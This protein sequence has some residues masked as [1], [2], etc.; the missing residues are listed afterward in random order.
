MSET[1]RK[2]PDLSVNESAERSAAPPLNQIDIPFEKDLTDITPIIFLV[3]MGVIVALVFILAFASAGIV[4]L[5][6]KIAFIS[7]AGLVAVGI[8]SI[9]QYYE[10]HRRADIR[11]MLDELSNR[12]LHERLESILRGN[13]SMAPQRM[14]REV[15]TRIA[16]DK[17]WGAAVRIGHPA[18]F[19]PLEPV[20]FTF[21]P[22]RLEDVADLT[23]MDTDDTARSSTPVPQ[24]NTPR[25]V[26]RNLLLKGGASLLVVFFIS[27]TA[28]LIDSIVHRRISPNLIW[29][30]VAL[31][32]FAFVPAGIQWRSQRQ[33]YLLPGGI[34][35]RKGGW[36]RKG[37]RL[38]LF[39]RAASC[40]LI[41]PLWKKQWVLVIADETECESIIGLKTELELALRA[42]LSPLEPPPLERLSDLQ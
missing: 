4:G 6:R 17:P 25:G 37:W 35:V 7:I 38:L 29:W 10:K 14:M 16:Q 20:P 41:Y 31:V 21:E 26:S 27:W 5:P 3:I 9:V 2:H 34:L 18:G 28:G 13:R 11:K 40:V 15:L 24:A 36:F 33:F 22:R 8:L 30:T 23:A 32:L 12:P 19:M 39:R 42:W 1:D